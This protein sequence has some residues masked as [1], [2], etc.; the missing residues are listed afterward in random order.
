MI[1]FLILLIQ[2]FHNFL[3]FGI[4]D[5]YSLSY[6]GIAFMLSTAI[7]LII[8]PIIVYL[9]PEIYETVEVNSKNRKK[10]FSRLIIVQSIILLL[11]LTIVN[12]YLEKI[13]I[14][15]LGKDINS[16]VIL[17][18][19]IPLSIS[20][21]SISVFNSLKILFIAE[22]KI[23]FMKKPVISIGVLFIFFTTL[24]CYKF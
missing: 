2:Q 10:N 16:S 7:P 19:L 17:A 15:W 20:A 5:P 4:L 6:F 24:I 12:F 18:Y 22:N 9:T 21:F 3:A 13:L 11:A 23:N 8:S 1:I 14:F